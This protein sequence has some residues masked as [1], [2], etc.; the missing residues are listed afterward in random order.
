METAKRIVCE[1]GTFGSSNGYLT[2]IEIDLLASYAPTV[3]S[4]DCS[5][6]EVEVTPL[7]Q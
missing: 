2:R 6:T 5:V 7:R 1:R 4:L 3:S